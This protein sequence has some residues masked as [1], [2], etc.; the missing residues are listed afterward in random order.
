MSNQSYDAS[1]FSANPNSEPATQE[2]ARSGEERIA[3]GM[4]CALLAVVAGAVLTVVIWRLGFIASITS[5]AMAA[6]A[7]Y[8]YSLG[9]GAAPRKGLVPLVLLI[10]LGVVVAFFA[11]VASDASDAYTMFATAASGTRTTFIMDN[12]FNGEVLSSYG[13]DMAM[14]GLFAVLGLFGTMRQLLRTSH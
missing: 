7:V 8:L 4:L 12:M 3:R 2:V 1:A 11:I 14:F 6:G 9:A 5:F 13:K 10:V